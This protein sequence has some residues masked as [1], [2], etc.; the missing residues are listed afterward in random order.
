MIHIDVDKYTY[1]WLCYLD[2]DTAISY[3]A[4]FSI[5]LKISQ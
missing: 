2:Y 3:V 1:T 4:T 5:I